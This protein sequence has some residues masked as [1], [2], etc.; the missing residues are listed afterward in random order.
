VSKTL[1]YGG[2][3]QRADLDPVAPGS[4]LFG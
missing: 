1:R 2:Q 3:V 4:A